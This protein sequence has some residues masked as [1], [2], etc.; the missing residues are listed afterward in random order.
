MTD[1]GT[2]YG[3]SRSSGAGLWSDM[4]GSGSA[5]DTLVGDPVAADLASN[6]TPSPSRFAVTCIIPAYNEEMSISDTVRSVL[7]QSDPPEFV[8]VVDDGSTDDT[9]RLAREAGA[10][11]VRPPNNTG[12]KAG[13]QTFALSLIETPLAMVLDADSTLSPDAVAELRDAFRDD[14]DLVAACSF[15]VPRSRRTI[16]ERGRYIEYLY[17][18]GHGKQIQDIYGRPLI[19]SGCFSMYQTSWLQEVGGWSTRTL[20]EDMDLTWTLY[21]L[22]GKVRFI[23]AAVCEPIEPDNFKMMKTQLRRWSHGFIQNVGVHWR[24]ILRQ[25][26]LRSVIAVSFWDSTISS[27]FYIVVLPIL[28]IIYGPIVLIGYVI[29]MPAIAVPVLYEANKR[30]EFRSAL[31]SLPAFFILR[32]V[33]SVQMLRALFA[34]IVL[35]KSFLTYEKGH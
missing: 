21:E 32:L 18:F 19:S 12:S 6:S 25:P 1:M 3:G 35:R 9:G 26:M 15:V 4:P 31:V 16:W 17:A 24:G 5:T 28:T 14:E 2:P 20:A 33:N 29:D 34:E 27:V 11:V 10:T 8:I 22:G 7:A 23:P 30:S 13:A